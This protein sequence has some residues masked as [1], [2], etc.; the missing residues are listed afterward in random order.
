MKS[1][2]YNQSTCLV[3][4]VAYRYYYEGEAVAC[5][6]QKINISQSTVSR[7]L[8]R[9][10]KEQ[11]IT[12]QMAQPSLECIQLARTIQQKYQLMDVLVSPIDTEKGQVP[13]LA[14]VKKQVALEGAR[15]LQRMITDEDI[16]GLAWG[17]T[18]Y[19]LIQYLNPCRRK[20]A[21]I[22]T[23]HGSIAD[24]DPK[25]AVQTLVKRAAMAFDGQ[26]ISIK[27]SG[28]LTRE[29]MDIL[30][31]TD[32]YRKIQD[33]FGR[34]TISVSGVGS[35]YPEV[36][37]LLATTQYL[38]E[39]ELQTLIQNQAYCDILL[40]FINYSGRECDTDLKDRTYSISLDAYRRIPTKIVV[41]SGTEKVTSIQALLNGQLVD[42]LIIDQFLAKGLL[43]QFVA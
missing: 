14:A 17:G 13:D 9:A 36:R 32:H 16:V 40:R 41:A 33:I 29:E 22:V 38:K 4:E 7:L 21:K 11:I 2:V 25:L 18:M 6:A 27:R 5:I 37:S 1:E 39:G 26:N 3:N 19:H 23:L 8:K 34:I 31:K 15:Y 20:G 28:L 12:F 35:F 42:V 30:R 10:E 43:N 24:C